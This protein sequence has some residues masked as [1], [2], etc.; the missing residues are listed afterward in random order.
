MKSNTEF[1]KYKVKNDELYLPKSGGKVEGEAVFTGGVRFSSGDPKNDLVIKDKT[2]L[3]LGSGFDPDSLPDGISAPI[4]SDLFIA[5]ESDIWVKK[6][7]AKL[8]NYIKGKIGLSGEGSANKFLNEKGTFTDMKALMLEYCYPVGSFYISTKNVSPQTF[9]G[10]TWESRSGYM[11]RAATS[12]VTFDKAN[13]TND[14]GADSVTVSS[15]ANHNHT[16]DQHRHYVSRSVSGNV[17]S[18][19]LGSY[20]KR[21][22]ENVYTNYVTATNQANGANYTVNTLPKYKNVYMWE[23][24]A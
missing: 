12:D 23:R 13:D 6:T 8:W 16:Q 14:G 1:N 3:K 10:G 20:I 24:T 7:F 5:K 15:V 2:S 21:A 22:Y 9:L 17:A 11:L 18:G 4:D 19:G